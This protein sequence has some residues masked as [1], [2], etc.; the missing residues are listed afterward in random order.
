[1]QVCRVVREKRIERKRGQDKGCHRIPRIY[2]RKQSTTSRTAAVE[3]REMSGG[4][5]NESDEEGR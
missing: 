5:I 4:R 1:M 3:V 2:E